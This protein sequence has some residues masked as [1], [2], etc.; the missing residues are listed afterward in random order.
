MKYHLISF[1]SGVVLTVL[2]SFKVE[3]YVPNFSIAEVL[4]VNELYTS[5]Q[6]AGPSWL[7]TR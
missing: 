3:D 5:S 1:L 6:T 7:M 4:K 2:L